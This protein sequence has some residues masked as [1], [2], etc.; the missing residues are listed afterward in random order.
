MLNITAGIEHYW[1]SNVASTL[2]FNWADLN[3]PADRTNDS[4]E[5]GSTVHANIRWGVFKR[6]VVG[7]EYMAGKQ[8]IVDGT[9]GF[10]QRI[11]FA[12]RL[13]FTD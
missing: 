5:M 3:S 1:A 6:F 12:A 11:Q 13:S 2:S 8:R 9:N 10:A 7:V 4:Q